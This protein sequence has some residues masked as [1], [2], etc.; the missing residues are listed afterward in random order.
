MSPV[1]C[2]LPI[3]PDDFSAGTKSK[4]HLSNATLN[5]I[6]PCT[7]GNCMNGASPAPPVTG[8]NSY[9]DNYIITTGPGGDTWF[10]IITII[11]ANGFD[12]TDP[13]GVNGTGEL[14]QITTQVMEEVLY[15]D[16]FAT[17]ESK[18]NNYGNGWSFQLNA[19]AIVNI[20]FG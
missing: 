1:G 9:G 18:I 17:V 11:R 19:E 6:L 14:D 4:Y 10:D 2:P 5:N 13:W 16:D 8:P 3:D 7:A 15:T 20:T 12:G